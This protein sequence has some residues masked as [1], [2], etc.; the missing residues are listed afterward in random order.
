MF[1]FSLRRDTTGEFKNIAHGLVP[2]ASIAPKPA[3][4]RTPPP[5]TPDPSPERTRSA[6]AAAILSSSLTGQTWAI[7]PARPRSFSESG[8]SE[9]FRSEPNFSTA[10]YTRGRRSGDLT[11]HPPSHSEEELE[12]SDEAVENEEVREEHVYHSLE[13]QDNPSVTEPVYTQPL[14]LLKTST[15]QP[16]QMSGRTGP[17]SDLTEEVMVQTPVTSSQPTKKKAS[18]RKS[19]R[20][21]REVVPTLP[22]TADPQIRS[23]TSAM[24]LSKDSCGRVQKKDERVLPTKSKR[25]P[26]FDEQAKLQERLE[27][28]EREITHKRASSDPKS[29]PGSEAELKNLRQHAQEL[30]DENDALK[31]MVHRLNVELS[32]YQARF[33]PMSRRESSRI[34]GLPK[35]GSAPPWL[36]DIKCFPPL[37]LAYEDRIHEKDA[38]LQTTEEEVKT[39]RAHV[40]EVIKENKSLHDEIAKSGELRQDDC[41]QLQHQAFL[42]LKENQVL[43]DQLEAQDVKAKASLTRHQSEVSKLMKELMLLEEEKQ[44]LQEELEKT[45][46]EAQENKREVQVLQAHLKDS[47]TWD[48]HC[49]IAGKL[50][51]EVEQQQSKSKNKLEELLHRLSSLQE[52][53][54]VLALDKSNV[55]AHLKKVESE[56][57]LRKQV[58]RKAERRLSVLKQQKDECVLKEKKTRQFMEAVLTAA[59]HVSKE[60]DQLL[61]MGSVLQQEKQGFIN[62]IV[63]GAVRFGKLQ[64]MIKE[65]RSQASTRLAALED[66]ADGKTESYQREIV[67]LQT[68]LRERREAEERLL[69]SKRDVEMELEVVWQA[70]TRE[71]QQIKDCFLNSKLSGGLDSH[72]PADEALTSSRHQQHLANSL[73]F[74]SHPK[75]VFQTEALFKMDAPLDEKQKNGLDFYC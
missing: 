9:T 42:V 43:T 13:R 18:T 66:A 8:Q 47:I 74:T 25:A 73:T 50:R 3:V 24:R 57:E 6:L 53:I 7:P 65:Y 40:E 2:A 23:P 49:S 15:P 34:R 20:S 51:R 60:R 54:R 46:R 11:S 72:P 22:P 48:E 55:T 64:E 35:T 19:S 12:D 58:S 10:L 16:N 26:D 1:K 52:E 30:V 33:K 62:R 28:L 37:L 39:L 44:Q 38:L 29:S 36:H 27:R 68:L 32:R 31:L 21:L 61:Q 59:Q 56:L 5:R 45:K 75:S 70:A 17:S 41:Q 14:K 63:N 67:R 71:N 69:Q 4:P